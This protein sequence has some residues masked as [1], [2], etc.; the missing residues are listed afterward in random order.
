[1]GQVSA[2]GFGCSGPPTRVGATVL[3]LGRKPTGG[4]L[5]EE[6]FEG[7]GIEVFEDSPLA[8][9]PGVV[10]GAWGT[11][12]ASAVFHD[13]AGN[14]EWTFHGF[15]GLPE[16]YLGRGLRQPGAPAATLFALD[17]ARVG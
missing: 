9:F 16:R 6:F 8:F 15:H 12:S 17:Q 2:Q 1:M 10:Q 7:L 14:G 3:G 11:F 4:V 5:H 13:A